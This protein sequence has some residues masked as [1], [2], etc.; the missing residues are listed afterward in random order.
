MD[1]A[2]TNF[3]FLPD[4]HFFPFKEI[5]EKFETL[6]RRSYIERPLEI[7]NDAIL[8][9]FGGPGIYDPECSHGAL[10]KVLDEFEKVFKQKISMRSCFYWIHLYRRLAPRLSNELGS[11]TGQITLAWTR[12]IAEQAIFKFGRVQGVFDVKL[13]NTIEVRDILGGHFIKSLTSRFHA[14]GESDFYANHVSKSPQWV[15]ADFGPSDLATMYFVEGLAYQYWYINAKQRAAGKGV[16]IEVLPDGSLNELRSDEQEELIR[17]YDNRLGKGEL[18]F[19]SNVGT[20]VPLKG[21][22]TESAV[23][24]VGHNVELLPISHLV[25]L[26]VQDANT[27]GAFIPNYLLSHLD[28]AEYY[29]THKYL[30][31]AFNK[32]Y[33]FGL[34]EFCLAAYAISSVLVSLSPKSSE[35]EL[36]QEIDLIH[37]IQRGYISLGV[38]L[39]KI[40]ELV[41]QFLSE[42]QLDDVFNGAAVVAQLDLIFSFL[43]LDE[44]K[45]RNLGIWSLGPRFAFIPYRNIYLFDLSAWFQIF[46]NLFFGMRNYDPRSAKGTE[47]ERIFS[48]LAGENGLEVV[49]ESKEITLGEQDREVDVAI[50]VGGHLFLCEC[51]SSERPLDFEIGKPKTINARCADLDEKLDQVLSLAD[52][53]R[54]YPRGKNYDFSWA[55]DIT[56]LVVSPY[57]EWIWSV[58]DKY[59]LPG[60]TP[61]PRIMSASEAIGYISRYKE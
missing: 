3:M 37:K 38:P 7:R 52:L 50:R 49:L 32:K 1:S 61:I 8:K 28:A 43:T 33:P 53:I 15:L 54:K 34:K 41:I 30:E 59:W 39:P 16:S 24:Y 40:K 36:Q 17:R 29:R 35:N 56:P 14:P 48:S 12:A 2:K 44:K 51:R 45:Q 42:A 11:N 26:P 23:I 58:D 55:S 31:K 9:H 4:Y 19:P 10:M 60:G 20:F 46:R 25:D 47:F 57:V 13:A 21:P 5:H 22:R 27:H 6:I 18:G